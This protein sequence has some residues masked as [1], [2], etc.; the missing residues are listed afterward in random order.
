MLI[1]DVSELIGRTPLLEIDPAVHGLK[2]IRLYAKL[3]HLNPFGSIKDR[4]ATGVL[5]EDF[6]EIVASGKTV[7]ESSSGNMAKALSILCGMRKVPFRIVSSKIQVKEVKQV[8]Q[9]LGAEIEEHHR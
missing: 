6:D 2:N 9:V 5:S 4:S 3:E 7:V 8:L 1:K